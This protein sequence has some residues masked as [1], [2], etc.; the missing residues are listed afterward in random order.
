MADQNGLGNTADLC[1]ICHLHLKFKVTDKNVNAS[2]F[3]D[4]C[5]KDGYRICA[6]RV[7]IVAKCAR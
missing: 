1:T 3:I 6:S 2:L 4:S 5:T 7:A